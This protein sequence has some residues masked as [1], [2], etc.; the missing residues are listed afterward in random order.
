VTVVLQRQRS[1][2]IACLCMFALCSE[3]G[4]DKDALQALKGTYTYSFPNGL[5]N[6]KKY[7]SQNKLQLLPITPSAAYFNVHLDWANG[8]VCNISGVA[9]IE[10]NEAELVYR[11]PSIEGK[12]CKLTLN[13]KREGIEIGDKAGAC[14]L[15]SCG[16]RGR[17][18]GVQFSFKSRA[19]IQGESIRKSRDFKHAW[20]EY[21]QQ[22]TTPSGTTQ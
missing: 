18:D 3:A 19:K 2:I 9:R 4:D 6:G 12:T 8:H 16:T 17:L 22:S 14:R 10:G 21:N 11:T 13:S 1:F 20:E 7:S 15:I 5:M